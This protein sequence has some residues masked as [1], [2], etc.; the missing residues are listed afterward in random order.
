[1]GNQCIEEIPVNVNTDSWTVK[2]ISGR[3]GKRVHVAPE[4]MFTKGRNM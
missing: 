3:A 1:M 4:S 2:A